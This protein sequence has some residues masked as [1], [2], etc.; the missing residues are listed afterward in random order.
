MASGVS[1]DKVVG[2][3]KEN[4]VFQYLLPFALVFAIIYGLLDELDIFSG[5]ADKVISAVLA[6]FVT[7]AGGG[8]I[9]SLL[10]EGS[11]LPSLAMVLVG[12]LGFMLV[13][14]M[15][16]GLEME[17]G[18]VKWIFGIAA[19]LVGLSLLQGSQVFANLPGDPT[20][21]TNINNLISIAVIGGIIYLMFSAM[22]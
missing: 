21:L 20:W 14:G 16:P 22:S 13:L 15:V 12:F 19:A 8:Q 1:M 9:Q 4:G 6:A 5:D 18:K 11:F 10:L 7:F 17:S 3:L 2:L